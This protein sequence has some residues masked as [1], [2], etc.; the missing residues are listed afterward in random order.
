[1]N[2]AI[3]PQPPEQGAGNIQENHD[4]AQTATDSSQE[5][6]KMRYI[7]SGHTRAVSSLKFS[8]DG[9]L[10]ASSGSD[11]LIKIWDAYT[12]DALSTF[13]GH[14]EGVS[15]VAW[16]YDGEHVASA[17]DDKTV[18]IWNVTLGTGAQTLVGHT[19]FV[20][21]VNYNLRSNLLVSGG[22]DETVRVWDVARGV[23]EFTDL[24]SR[25]TLKVLPAHSDPVTAVSF[26]HDG[27]LI[28]SCSMDGLIRIWDSDSGQCLK[29]IV[30]DDNPICSHVK[31]SAN[32][33]FVLVS[34]QDSTI[35]LWDYHSSRCVKTYTGHT[36]RVY[37]LCACFSG[38]K[39][40]TKYIVSGSEDN[41]AY[42]WNLQ[43]RKIFQVL[44]GHRDVVL[45]VATH[46]TIE[47]IATASM[48]KDPSIRLWW[49]DG[50]VIPNQE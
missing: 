7:L 27:T 28:V 45:A 21:C 42:I 12:G 50:I 5:Q 48:E 44:E 14:K 3:D 9:T 22:F 23:S 40:S 26:N 47:I 2:G 11:K 20:F 25:M 8:P 37:C 43:T 29:T 6:F 15:D 41:K 32:S 39:T 36:N 24:K 10:L 46:P 30:D 16:S 35:R 17:S 13:E 38:S 31:F 19:S 33:R 1:M 4:A 49:P 18:K 34:T